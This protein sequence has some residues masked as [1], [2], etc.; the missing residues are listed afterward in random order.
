MAELVASQLRRRI[1]GGELDDGDELP[2]EAELL[3]AFGVSRPSLREG[4]RILETEGL[5]R[6]RR[7]KVGGAVIQRPTAR[8]TAYHVALTLQ[9]RHATLSDLA[10]ARAVLEPACAGIAAG[11]DART[12]RRI[13]AALNALIEENE[14]LLGESYAFTECALHFHAAIVDLSGNVTVSL[15]TGSLEAVWSTQERHWAKQTT[16]EG[17]YPAA[18]DQREVLRAHRRIASA[19]EQGDADGAVRSLHVHLAKSQPYVSKHDRPLDV[20]NGDATLPHRTRP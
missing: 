2:R 6:I 5:I 4:L 7:G 14:K 3:E 19:I 8:S 16:S 18:A 10:Q 17:A 12:R 20:L 1:I 13:V 11:R 9:S 15:L